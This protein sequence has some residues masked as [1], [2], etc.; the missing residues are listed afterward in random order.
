MLG[1]WQQLHG[2]TYLLPES[3]HSRFFLIG[4]YVAYLV[5]G[6][7]ALFYSSPANTRLFPDWWQYLWGGLF[8]TGGLLCVFG[9][10]RKTPIGGMLGLPLLITASGLYGA[11]LIYRFT[12]EH[13][14]ITLVV[15]AL[16]FGKCCNLMDRWIG[17]R[18]LFQMIQ[19][20]RDGL[21]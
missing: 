7:L 15:A 9:V 13:N 5:A 2:E 3:Q 21:E 16:M 10:L 20:S 17:T 8:I 1:R 6:P 4:Y 19:E 14:G 11:S 18:N 12:A